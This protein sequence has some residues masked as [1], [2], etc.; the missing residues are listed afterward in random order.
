MLALAGATCGLLATGPT[1]ALAAVSESNV[2]SPADGALLVQNQL[3]EPAKTF[4]VA[5]TSNGTTGDAV[6]ILC[7]QGE[8]SVGGYKGPEEKG[9]SARPV[10]RL[11]PER[12]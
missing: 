12:R 5:G 1:A 11:T 9:A 10:G 8:G 3:T 7:Y 6:D 2:T 4:T